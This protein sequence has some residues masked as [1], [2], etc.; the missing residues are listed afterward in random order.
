[1]RGLPEPS[2]SI[3]RGLQAEKPFVPAG[4]MGETDVLDLEISP[5]FF[6]L[7][8][9]S[10]VRFVE[11]LPKF[12]HLDRIA[13]RKE[14]FKGH[15]IADHHAISSASR[16]IC[17]GGSKHVRKISQRGARLTYK[18]KDNAKA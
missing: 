15:R 18:Q 9:P 17:R 8:R 4:I 7:L 6:P 13:R 10:Q 5:S 2:L 14:N 16:T 12:G 3:M 1:M 11:L